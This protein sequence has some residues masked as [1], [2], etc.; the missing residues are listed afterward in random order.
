MTTNLFPYIFGSICTIGGIYIIF[1]SFNLYKPKFKE[2]QK[3][4]KFENGLK[5]F[6]TFYKFISFPILILG[7]YLLISGNSTIFAINQNKSL[8]DNW[9]S[10]DSI[11]F[12]NN[13]INSS[14]PNTLVEIKLSEDYCNCAFSKIKET[15]KRNEYLE[16]LKLS[17]QELLEIYEQLFLDCWNEYEKNKI[18]QFSKDSINNDV[19]Y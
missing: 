19:I 6:G 11:D 3:K 14:A 13:C 17:D 5:K 15:Y 18:K 2:T 4:E 8:E 7:I 12:V 9:T 16:I 1:I 10:E